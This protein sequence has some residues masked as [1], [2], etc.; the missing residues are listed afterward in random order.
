MST[1]TF[2]KCAAKQAG[3]SNLNGFA[4]A[5]TCAGAAEFLQEL[6]QTLARSLASQFI[7]LPGPRIAQALTEA[8]ALAY[9]TAF[10]HF[11]LPGLAEEK[12]REAAR[13]ATRQSTLRA[14]RELPTADFSA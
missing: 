8:E 3:A 9:Q 13:W 6:N 10:P 5:R 2:P 1:T 4:I 11:L 7:H 14:P 12:V